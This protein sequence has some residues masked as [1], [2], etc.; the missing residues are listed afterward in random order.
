MNKEVKDLIKKLK[1]LV[2]STNNPSQSG[3]LI[4]DL[5]ALTEALKKA[6]VTSGSALEITDI[7]A[8]HTRR[9]TKRSLKALSKS[10]K[11]LNPT[12]TTNKGDVPGKVVYLSY[13]IRWSSRKSSK[14]SGNLQENKA[15][16]RIARVI[17][18]LSKRGY[19]LGCL[20]PLSMID[21]Y[22]DTITAPNK[23]VFLFP[24]VTLDGAKYLCQNP[25][26][27]LHEDGKVGP[28]LD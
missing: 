9:F 28:Q 7:S 27:C 8:K 10:V 18:D 16:F 13:S 24:C 19:L 11:F 15:A 6:T 21:L 1:A 12:V 17:N 14:T 5:E 26:A 2:I 4:K 20:A 22:V 23:A 25:P 3:T